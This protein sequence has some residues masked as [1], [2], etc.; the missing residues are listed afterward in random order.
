MPWE[1]HLVLQFRHKRGN[2]VHR[3][4][5]WLQFRWLPH[6]PDLPST[7]PPSTD[8]YHKDTEFSAQRSNKKPLFLRNPMV[9]N[10]FIS[11]HDLSTNFNSEILIQ[12]WLLKIH[13]EVESYCCV[14][15]S[16]PHSK[17]FQLQINVRQYTL[18]QGFCLRL[19]YSLSQHCRKVLELQN[20]A[21]SCFEVCNLLYLNNSRTP[22]L[23]SK[24]RNLANFVPDLGKDFVVNLLKWL[25][26]TRN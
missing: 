15:L 10:L 7:T 20:K 16:L 11:H 5:V 4:A 18:A 12:R 25:I 3:L 22:H 13:W 1:N 9:C 2:L 8:S 17:S 23:Q 24:G 6:A 21:Q 14:G 26:T 19:I